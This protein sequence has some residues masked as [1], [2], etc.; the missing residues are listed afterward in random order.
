MIE[1]T[2]KSGETLHD[3]VFR[4]FGDKKGMVDK[5]LEANRHLAALGFTY[6]KDVKIT[7]PTIDETEQKQQKKGVSLWG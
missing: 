5:V 7:I 6:D 4:F 2:T 1:Y 3:I